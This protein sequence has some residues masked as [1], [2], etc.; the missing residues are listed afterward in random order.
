MDHIADFLKYLAANRGLSPTT[1]KTYGQDLRALERFLL[2]QDEQLDWALVDRDRIRLWVADRMSGPVRPQTIKRSLSSL[3]T[4]FRY[5]CTRAVI[6]ADPMQL[7]P[8]PKTP[9]ALPACVR[10][11]EMDRLLDRTAFPDTFT[12]RRDHLILLTFYSAGLRVSELCRLNLSDVDHDRSELR[13]L[14]KGNKQRVVPFGPELRDAL[15]LYAAERTALFGGSGCAPFFVTDR[16]RRVNYALVHD[17]VRDYLS[18]VTTATKRTP[19]VLRHTFATVMLNGGA[20][21]EAVK[22]LL[23]HASIATT[24]IYTHTTFAELRRAY[25]TAHPREAGDTKKPPAAPQILKDV[26]RE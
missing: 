18:L 2:T 6:T 12:G 26:N 17:V 14:G 10:R 11:E 5:L 19:H 25:E 3:R 22:S 16:G 8:N 4:F 7:I 1:V 20:D 21:L 15:A 23:G 13:V 24:Q 9:R